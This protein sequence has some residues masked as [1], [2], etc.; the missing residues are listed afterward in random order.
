MTEGK[1]PYKKNWGY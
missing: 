1:R